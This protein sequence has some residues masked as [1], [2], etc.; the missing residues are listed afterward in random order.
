MLAHP[1]GRFAPGSEQELAEWVD[2]K[3][4]TAALKQRYGFQHDQELYDGL[5]RLLRVY[6][7]LGDE[8]DDSSIVE[9]DSETIGFVGVGWTW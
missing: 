8:I 2:P 1:S 9:E 5:Y 6:K 4:E 7:M 3:T